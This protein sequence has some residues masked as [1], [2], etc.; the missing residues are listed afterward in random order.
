M[1]DWTAFFAVAGF[2]LFLVVALARVTA[3]ATRT[4]EPVR[5]AADHGASGEVDASVDDAA[6]SDGDTALEAELRTE[7]S[8]ATD[9]AASGTTAT[10]G[11]PSN[12][13]PSNAAA[14]ST[15]SSNA[16]QSGVATDTDDESRA[17]DPREN[18][19]PSVE[20]SPSTTHQHREQ[21]GG[22]VALE[23]ISTGLLL[24]NVVLTHGLLAVV[25][26]GAAGLTAIPWPAL[27]ID[28]TALSTGLPAVGWGV[29][30]GLALALANGL[31]AA[32]L[33]RFGLEHSDALRS[34]LAPDG[35]V[36]WGV[37]LLVILPLVSL[38][39]ELLF[40]A[41]LVGALATWSGLSPWLLVVPASIAFAAGH[42]LQGKGGVL[43]TGLLGAVLAVAFVLTNSLLLVIVAH[44]VVNA[45]EFLL[46][47]WLGVDVQERLAV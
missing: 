8:S 42:G 10:D 19:R 6:D 47:E 20:R 4:D 9:A 37:L 16:T 45:V 27:G 43:V 46:Q 41:V 22:D 18:E 1:P 38:F 3:S 21:S 30:L 13:A 7:A 44:Y 17:N 33:D 36:G 34:A 15:A 26:L 35:P 23:S 2:V 28:A 12:T 11:A 5:P 32:N 25:L 14:S 40:R 29:A 39:E 24:A 31:L